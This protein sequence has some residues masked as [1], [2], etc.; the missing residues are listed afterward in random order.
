[1]KTETKNRGR[2]ATGVTT[3]MVRIPNALKPTVMELVKAYRQE[4]KGKRSRS[5]L[6]VPP[7]TPSIDIIENQVTN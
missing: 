6:A 4:T 3:V 1:V 5:S 7:S 2:P